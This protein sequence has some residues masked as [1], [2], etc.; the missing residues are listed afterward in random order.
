MA[1]A[2]FVD[3][4]KLR[5]GKGAGEQQGAEQR[6]TVHQVVHE[7]LRVSKDRSDAEPSVLAFCQVLVDKGFQRQHS[8]LI[9]FFVEFDS[10]AHLLRQLALDTADYARDGDHAQFF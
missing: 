1:N 7:F 2:F 4:G 10:V 8:R 5:M 9:D 3:P 6:G